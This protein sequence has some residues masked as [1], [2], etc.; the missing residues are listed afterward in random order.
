MK[1]PTLTY[2]IAIE[3]LQLL[4]DELENGQPDLDT[5]LAHVAEAQTLITYCRTRLRDANTTL[6]NLM[7]KINTPA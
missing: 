6:D 2:T 7:A 3:R 1:K 5:M 4:V